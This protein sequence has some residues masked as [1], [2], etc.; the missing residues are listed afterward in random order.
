MNT[1]CPLN[2]DGHTAVVVFKQ[3]RW[4]KALLCALA[5]FALTGSTV[6]GQQARVEARQ[7]LPAPEKIIGE[8]WKAVG[9]KKRLA[10]VKVATYEWTFE[11][12]RAGSARTRER[13]P[14]AVR[15]DLTLDNG[16]VT[17]AASARSA[18]M[19]GAD[20][21][22][23]TLT[24]AEAGAAKLQAA[25]AA[26]RLIDYKKLNV[27]ARTVAL[28]RSDAEAAYVLEFSTRAGARLRYSF[29]VQTKLLLKIDDVARQTVTRFADY[30]AESSGL[31]VPHRM[32]IERAAQSAKDDL[33]ASLTL[34][35][36]RV[37]YDANFSDAVFDPPSSEALDIP[38]LLKEVE[39]N[40]E[41]LDER[42]SEYAFTEKRT[43]RKIN[44]KGEIKEEKVTV[45]EIYPL[46]GG[47]SFYKVISENGVPLSA[48][49]AAKQD[50]TIAEFVAK[51]ER[52]RDER[53]QK[54]KEAA[55][56]K[57]GEEEK[58]KDDDDDITVAQFLNACEFVSPRR[59][60]LR[61][62][63]AVVFDF[64]PRP[65]FRPKN[66]A[67]DI[68]TKLIGIVWIDPS[69]KQVIRLEAKLAEGYKMGGGLVASI[70]PGSSF[71]FEQTRIGDGVWLP[72]FAQVNFSA[73]IFLFKGIEA[74]ETREFSDYRHFET[75]TKDYK[76][77][78]PA[79]KA[80]APQ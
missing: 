31:L 15:T 54:K 71:V 33:P 18:W 51:Y 29:G 37:S 63:E 53:E 23:R 78:T 66:R 28:D 79:S 13:F 75:E 60:R 80:P 52:E 59:E 8:Y 70:R 24:D 21:S 45:Y 14:A 77:D 44:D 40:Q 62:R 19:R 25:L 68:I 55:E 38:S 64:R 12:E 74:N 56:K 72:R 43:E 65:G 34:K 26:S 6:Y 58:K 20:G 4:L 16:E 27:L 1:N 5:L 2:R 67:E 9:G 61:D 35:L 50:K 76:L 3:Q 32:Q 69:D 36:Q 39:K 49:R 22:L 11:G 7:K 42:V 57:K 17:S 46:Q 48:E 73:K 41:K 47:G 10:G 30:R